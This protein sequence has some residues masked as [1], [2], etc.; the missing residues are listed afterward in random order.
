MGWAPLNKMEKG[1]IDGRKNK[2]NKS[3]QIFKNLSNFNERIYL[4]IAA[5]KVHCQGEPSNDPLNPKGVKTNLHVQNLMRYKFCSEH[6]MHFT[7]N[8]WLS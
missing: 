6:V 8:S 3:I 4:D 2:R 7:W 1:P 5:L